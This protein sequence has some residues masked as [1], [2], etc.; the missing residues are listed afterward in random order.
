MSPIKVQETKLAKVATYRR[1]LQD[2]AETTVHVAKY[3]RASIKPQV[4]T[5]DPAERLLDYCET[6]N[7]QDAVSGGFFVRATGIPLGEVWI[8]G[9]KQ[10][11][12]RFSEPWHDRR[13]CMYAD[14]GDIVLDAFMNLGTPITGDLLQAG[15]LLIKDGTSLVKRGSDL[16]G[17]SD[18]SSQFDSDISDG[19]YPRAALGLNNDHLFVVVCD[20]RSESEAGL[21]FTELADVLLEIGAEDGLNLDGGSSATLIAGQQLLNHPRALDKDY[22]RGRPVHTAIIFNPR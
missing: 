17:F 2:N 10:P 8:D 21:S 7:V 9:Q 5:F 20:G 16:E 3:D 15:P 22:E 14:D 19:R 6:H 4:I 13:G 18:G 1:K 12:V 11:S